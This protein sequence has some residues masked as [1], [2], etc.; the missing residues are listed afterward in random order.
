MG[1][2]KRHVAENYV[3]V[4]ALLPFLNSS[5]SR[6][7][8]H[9]FASVFAMRKGA[10]LCATQRI[11]VSWLRSSVLFQERTPQRVAWISCLVFGWKL[12][13]EVCTCVELWLAHSLPN[14]WRCSASSF[15]FVFCAGVTS[16]LAWAWMQGSGVRCCAQNSV[17][18][19]RP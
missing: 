13:F 17:M 4:L 16:C 18:N 2:A 10:C 12:Q 5:L 8:E 14:G 7:V 1:D 3:L 11:C 15:F 6:R 19:S 9:H